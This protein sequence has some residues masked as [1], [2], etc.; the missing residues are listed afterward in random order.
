MR[1]KAKLI[2]VFSSIILFYTSWKLGLIMISGSILIVLLKTCTH[3][4]EEKRCNRYN[5]VLNKLDFGL[6][7]S[8]GSK[9]TTRVLNSNVNQFE[10]ANASIE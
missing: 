10:Q 9:D 2:V 1:L 3:H 8:K 7:C 6:Y 5:K 4:F